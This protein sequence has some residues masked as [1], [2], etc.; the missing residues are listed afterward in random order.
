MFILL[1]VYLLFTIDSVFCH[2]H[3]VYE[4]NDVKI[5]NTVEGN[6]I[7]QCENNR[8]LLNFTLPPKKIFVNNDITIAC[9]LPENFQMSKFL[10]DL[11]ANVSRLTIN[12]KFKKHHFVGLEDLSYLSITNYYN[13]LEPDLL[14]NFSNLK[15]F[16]IVSLY[17]SL[18]IP[19]YFFNYSSNL[20]LLEITDGIVVRLRKESFSG[21]TNLSVLK[22]KFSGHAY[23]ENG[24]FDNLKYLKLLNISHKTLNNLPQESFKNLI[25][26]ETIII[27]CEDYGPVAEF[28]KYNKQILKLPN[29]LFFKLKLKT[30]KLLSIG[31]KEITQDIFQENFGLLENLSISGYY[32]QTLPSGIFNNTWK[33]KV[34]QI[35]HNHL[36][37][38]PIG[39]FKNLQE[40]EILDLSHN[41]LYQM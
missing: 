36:V 38:L 17:S 31:P 6:T 14:R 21:L 39:I 1:C 35:T 20:R 37:V 11:G 10:K 41:K 3:F 24:T 29:K 15:E 19:K 16:R 40:L 26:L 30:L 22:L 7:I 34:L 18:E 23:I 32:L 27:F 8:D 28:Q 33:I 12:N 4:D 13:D 2:Y 9:D 5:R 25:H